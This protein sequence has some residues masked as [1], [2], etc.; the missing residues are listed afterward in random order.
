MTTIQYRV[1]IGK[2]DEL[3]DGPDDAELVVTV[4]LDDGPRPTTSTP[5]SPTCGAS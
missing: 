1:I 4:P 5:P 2:K 3:V